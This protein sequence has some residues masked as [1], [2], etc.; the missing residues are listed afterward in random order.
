MSDFPPLNSPE[1]IERALRFDA[2]TRG[3]SLP[4]D[5]ATEVAATLAALDAEEVLHAGH[6]YRQAHGLGLLDDLARFFARFVSFPSPAA[7]DAVVLWTMHTHAFDAAETTPRLHLQSAEK[8]SGKSRTLELLEMTAANA[9]ATMNMSAAALYRVVE[10]HHP[11]LLLDEV[12]TVFSKGRDER[13]EDLRG[14][15][16]AGHR[17]GARAYRCSGMKM[18]VVKAF[19]VFCPVALSGIGDIPGTLAD[20]SIPIPMR[21]K[22]QAEPVERLR[23]RKVG[24]EAEALRER[25][26]QWAADHV[27]DLRTAEPSIPDQLDDRAADGWEPLLAIA[28][29]FG[30]SWPVRARAA[31]LELSAGK[32][33]E[34]DTIGVRLLVD[35]R[36][37]FGDAERL[38]SAEL[39]SRLCRIE[40]A[41]WGAWYGHPLDA[42]GLAKMLKPFDIRP[43][44]VRFGDDTA[45]GYMR[46]AFADAWARYLPPNGGPDPISHFEPEHPEQC[47]SEALFDPEQ[48]SEV[49]QSEI[50]SDL[51]RSDVPPQ[52][53][54]MGAEELSGACHRCASR[55]G[56]VD[57]AGRWWCSRCQV[58]PAASP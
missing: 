27:D 48:R 57:D 15:L 20:R 31:A 8:R 12:D 45:Q 43:R 16:N 36:T 55:T 46:D 50:P 26:A 47:R 11:T 56:L 3:G 37:V 7:R 49:F 22:T 38:S 35:C 52:N 5:I 1:S 18:E 28:D 21:R 2:A 9:H 30:G 14:L 23:R 17:R 4:D 40:E 25:L 6:A 32:M 54:H 58:M 10:E 44:K 51:Q 33:A 53:G 29:A 41:P 39:A 24:P 19:H 34:D 13:N 42:R